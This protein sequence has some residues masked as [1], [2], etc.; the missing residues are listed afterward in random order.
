MCG[1]G[2]FG[3]GSI[4]GQI[5]G[6]SFGMGGLGGLWRSMG[7][8]LSWVCMQKWLKWVME[9]WGK[10]IKISIGSGLIVRKGAIEGQRDEWKR[11][12]KRGGGEMR[13]RGRKLDKDGRF[14]VKR[15]KA[16]DSANCPPHPLP[17][18][19][20]RL[21]FRHRSDHLRSVS[22]PDREQ[23]DNASPDTSIHS[24]LGGEGWVWVGWLVR[25]GCIWL[26]LAGRSTCG[27][28]KSA[29]RGWNEETSQLGRSL[30]QSFLT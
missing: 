15:H 5:E 8:P 10:R 24:A 1:K 23:Q 12:E 19:A 16:R 17:V 3:G 28:L 6:L 18:G 11:K 30:K 9:L 26:E 22:L 14:G 29:F 21:W 13:G 7:A 4:L 25:G 20:Q 27:R 2:F